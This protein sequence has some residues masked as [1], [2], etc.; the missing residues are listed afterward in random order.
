M[1]IDES[2]ALAERA[3]GRAE[4]PVS[5]PD[6]PVEPV[7]GG[8]LARDLPDGLHRVQLRRVGRQAMQFDA[9]RVLAEPTLPLLV[10][11]VAGPV[12]SDEEDLLCGVPGN[13]E[14][15]EV[16]VGFSVEDRSKLEGEASCPDAHGTVEMGGL[17]QPE[18]V[19]SRLL[20]YSRPG[21]VERAVEPE[22]GFVLEEDLSA[23]TGG[24]FLIAGNSLRSQYSCFSRS[25]RANRLRGRCTEKPKR[26]RTQ[27]T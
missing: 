1:R 9:V 20:A 22:A 4:G 27:G 15:E 6:G 13:E 19:D 17:A 2:R 23:T 3:E 8:H 24:F 21:A 26:C 5:F 16:Q 25:A 7:V 18:R 12:V 11:V 10:Q 14:L